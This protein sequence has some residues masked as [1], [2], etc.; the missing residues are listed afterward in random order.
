MGFR[1]TNDIKVLLERLRS[2]KI[3]EEEA[4]SENKQTE[5]TMFTAPVATNKNIQARMLKSIIPDP[6]QF[7]GDQTK[8]KN[9]W[10]GIRL[11]LKSNRVTKTD[12]R[13]TAILACLREGVTGIYTQKKLDEID[14]KEGTQNQEDFV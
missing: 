3:L 5:T 12:D 2:L 13:I 9:Q 1:R 6:G 10:K 8:F 14:D 4:S 11:F 7:D